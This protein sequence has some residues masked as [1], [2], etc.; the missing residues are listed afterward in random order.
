MREIELVDEFQG[1]FIQGFC[2]HVGDEPVDFDMGGVV[3]LRLFDI[4]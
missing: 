1:F 3:G 2:E 4:S